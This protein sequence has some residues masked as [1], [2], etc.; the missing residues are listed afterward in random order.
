MRFTR[1]RAASV[2]VAT[3]SASLGGLAHASWP[4]GGD[5]IHSCMN[6]ANGQVRVVADDEPCKRNETPL[7][8]NH[9]GPQGVP[10][11]TGPQGPQGEMGPKGDKGDPGERG[12]TGPIGPPGPKGDK[13]EQGLPGP[14]GA[15]GLGEPHRVEVSLPVP[16][17]EEGATGVYCPVGEVFTGGGYWA[18]RLDVRGALPARSG[19]R[20]GY[21]VHAANDTS[22]ERTLYV[23]TMCLPVND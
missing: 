16:A 18:S 2:A 22:E 4:T 1:A 20:W 15:S 9:A 17:D 12:S 23:Y 11:P 21:Y 14:A 19:D 13:G 8:W 7:S 6:E 5:V 10:G 3:I